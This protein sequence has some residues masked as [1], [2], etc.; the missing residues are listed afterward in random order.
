MGFGQLQICLDR[1]SVHNIVYYNKKKV[2]TRA[3]T[4]NYHHDGHAFLIQTT[5]ATL[6]AHMIIQ[7][8]SVSI[9]AT[10]HQSV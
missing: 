5:S 10:S 8:T 7:T 4:C 1:L 6:S 3:P 2:P 9:S